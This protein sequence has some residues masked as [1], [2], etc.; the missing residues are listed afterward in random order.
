MKNPKNL[1]FKSRSKAYG[2][3]PFHFTALMQLKKGTSA[4]NI[5]YTMFLTNWME[6][7]VKVTTVHCVSVTATL[8]YIQLY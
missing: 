3:T 8:S 5:C 1:K 4:R 2:S 6:L 7:L